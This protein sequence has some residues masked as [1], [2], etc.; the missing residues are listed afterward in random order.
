M[1]AAAVGGEGEERGLYPG[2]LKSCCPAVQRI[3]PVFGD[4][5]DGGGEGSGANRSNNHGSS[6]LELL[7]VKGG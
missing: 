4:N 1:S 6:A 5:D 2:N 3:P 7:P